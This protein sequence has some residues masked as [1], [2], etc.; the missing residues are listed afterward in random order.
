MSFLSSSCNLYEFCQKKAKKTQPLNSTTTSDDSHTEAIS[1]KVDFCSSVHFLF[2]ITSDIDCRFVGPD[3]MASV[4]WQTLYTKQLRMPFS[5][6]FFSLRG[7]RKKMKFLVEERGKFE[8]SLYQFFYQFLSVLWMQTIHTNVIKGPFLRYHASVSWL[9]MS[10][11]HATEAWT[12]KNG[13]LMTFVF[14]M[15]DLQVEFFHCGLWVLLL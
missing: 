9:P 15:E 10:T 3:L 2:A 5:L 11:V 12:L 14:C 1:L 8:E 7:T 13:V 6:G 4:L